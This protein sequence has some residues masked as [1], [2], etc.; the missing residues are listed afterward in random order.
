M[1]FSLF[2]CEIRNR[3]LRLLQRVFRFQNL[4]L[5]IPVR[6]SGDLPRRKLLFHIRLRV[7][8]LFHTFGSSFD[9]LTE[10]FL[11][12]RE[13]FRVLRVK[14][15]QLIY[16]AQLFGNA[17]AVRVH[18]L[19]CLAEPG[20][21]TADLH[22]D[23]LDRTRHTFTSFPVRSTAAWTLCPFPFAPRSSSSLNIPALF[24]SG[25]MCI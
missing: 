12:L 4:T 16:F 24:G 8:E 3:R 25:I 11:L 7:T 2:F 14:F 20:S 10:K 18:I 13:H 9:R 6:L 22:C 1:R 5:K 15:E 23:S 17:G 19:Q 21:L